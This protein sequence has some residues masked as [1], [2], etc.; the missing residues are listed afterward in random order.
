MTVLWSADFETGDMSQ[1]R[2]EMD[3]NPREDSGIFAR[4]I[5]KA[6][7]HSGVYAMRMSIN[8]T[9]VSGCRTFRKRECWLNEQPNYYG[10]WFYFPAFVKVRGWWN[11]WQYKSNL[12]GKSDVAWKLEVRNPTTDTM[13][14]MLVWELPVDGP[15]AGDGNQTATII[16]QTPVPL[17]VAK[18]VHIQCYLRQSEA[19]DGQITVWH[20]GVQ[21]FDEDSVRTKHPG[22]NQNWSVNNYGQGLLTNGKL[23]KNS[24]YVDDMCVSTQPIV[25][26]MGME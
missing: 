5:T 8:S 10:A 18:W 24:L 21:V 12:D 26:N 15:R 11:I 16:Q 25:G 1:F 2:D 13:A 3:S 23:V 4:A 17:P 6:V 7:A 14:L 19:Y 9:T 22:G 20:D